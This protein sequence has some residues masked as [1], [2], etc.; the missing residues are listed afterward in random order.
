MA[1]DYLLQEDGVSHIIL[2]DASGNLILESS[3][4]TST[5]VIAP[6]FLLTG[7]GR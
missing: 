6:Q 7:L 3:V 2:E 5:G 1:I 4:L